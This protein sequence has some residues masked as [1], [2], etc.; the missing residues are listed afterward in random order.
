MPFNF[1]P[2]IN[3][4]LFYRTGP[5]RPIFT[6]QATKYRASQFIKP[7]DLGNTRGPLDHNS[8]ILAVQVVGT[9][10]KL[11]ILTLILKVKG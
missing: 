10:Y 2:A 11:Q 9:S 1:F 4:S 3:L 5:G 6:L 8:N 7:I